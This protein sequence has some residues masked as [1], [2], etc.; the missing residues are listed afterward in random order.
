MNRLVSKMEQLFY[1]WNW[2]RVLSLFYAIRNINYFSNLKSVKKIFL[3]MEPQYGNLGDQA[4]ALASEKYISDNFQEYK[5]ITVNEKEICKYLFAV[6]KACNDDD[7]IFI[8]GGGNLGTLYLRIERMRRLCVSILKKQRVIILPVSTNYGHKIKDKFERNISRI[9]YSN[10]PRLQ[11]L[12]RDKYAYRYIKT[13]FP[14][15]NCKLVPDIVY[16]LYKYTMANNYYN[17][18]GEVLICLRK[19]SESALGNESRDNLIVYLCNKI[20]NVYLYDTTV[21]RSVSFLVRELELNSLFLRFRN[22]KYV[23]TDRMHGMIFSAILGKP[24][25]VIKSID[26]KIL[27]SYDWINTSKNIIVIDPTEIDS[28]IEYMNSISKMDDISSVLKNFDSLK[29]DLIK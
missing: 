8:Q 7:I 14:K 27:G 21:S 24:C 16:Y 23:I 3:L 26:K 17:P 15:V 12:A 10:H 13:Y 1:K 28:A 4:I 22:A 2:Y 25:I 5:L 29:C 11:I 19:E 20:K 9:V 6:K 18:D